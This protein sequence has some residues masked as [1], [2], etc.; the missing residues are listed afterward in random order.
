VPGH[1]TPVSSSL[2]LVFFTPAIAL[3]IVA[4]VP[5]AFH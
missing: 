5:L 1:C 4:T 2:N 3:S